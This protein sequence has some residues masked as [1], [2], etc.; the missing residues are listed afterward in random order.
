MPMGVGFTWKDQVCY[1]F[2][3]PGLYLYLS[4]SKIYLL[5]IF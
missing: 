4:I 5:I 1:S 3:Q 2:I